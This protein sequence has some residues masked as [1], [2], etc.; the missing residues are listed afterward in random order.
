MVFVHKTEK[1]PFAYGEGL[2]MLHVERVRVRARK[3]GAKLSIPVLGRQGEESG[4]GE[5]SCCSSAYR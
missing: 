4:C 5:K 3:D 1:S 2:G